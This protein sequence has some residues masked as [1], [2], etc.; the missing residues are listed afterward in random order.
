MNVAM[1]FGIMLLVGVLSGMGWPPCGR[2]MAYW[3]S[4][5]ERSFKMSLWNTSHTIGSGSLGII[6]LMGVALFTDLGIPHG[7]LTLSFRL[8]SPS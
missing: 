4:N 3:F 2:V 5:N 6:A 8:A 7:V 1:L